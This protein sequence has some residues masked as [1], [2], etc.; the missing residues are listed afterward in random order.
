MTITVLTSASGSPGVTT[1]AL[2]LTL[3]WPE[4]C[5]LIDGDYQQA[6]LTGY[7]QG[8]Y[9]TTNGMV[10]VI[11]AARISPDVEEAVWRQAIPLPDDDENGRRR[12]LLNGLSTGQDW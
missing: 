4:S 2:G 8:H 9:V 6:V 1:T 7:L 5:M 10:H 11:N 3:T 12:L